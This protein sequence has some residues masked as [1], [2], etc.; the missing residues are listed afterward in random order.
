MQL[1]KEYETLCQT[2]NRTK[3]AET[4]GHR[5]DV[6]FKLLNELYGLQIEK[7]VTE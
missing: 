4:M 3:A 2:M 5:K 7:C 6:M 1:E